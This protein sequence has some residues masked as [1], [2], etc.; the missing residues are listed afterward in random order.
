MRGGTGEDFW[1]FRPGGRRRAVQSLSRMPLAPPKPPGSGQHAG[2]QQHSQEITE[3][4]PSPAGSF[5]QQRHARNLRAVRAQPKLNLQRLLFQRGVGNQPGRVVI[6][7]AAGT[8]SAVALM[9]SAA[10][11][12]RGA[13]EALPLGRQRHRPARPCGAR[14]SPRGLR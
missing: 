8:P 1:T 2:Q 9:R 3:P 10:Y 6:T 5:F 13:A 12:V 11:G 14:S 4:A 7:D